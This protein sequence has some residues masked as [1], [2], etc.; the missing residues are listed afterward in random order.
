MKIVN[1]KWDVADA[2][3]GDVFLVRGK[4]P[5]GTTIKTIIDGAEA[6]FVGTSRTTIQI[7]FEETTMVFDTDKVQFFDPFIIN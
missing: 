4:V 6:K 2:Q 7:T 3:E 1:A 5:I